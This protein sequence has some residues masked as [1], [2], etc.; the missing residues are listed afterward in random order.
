MLKPHRVVIDKVSSY[1]D[2]AAAFMRR[3]R[4][5][6]RE[7]VRIRFQ[8]GAESDLPSGAPEAD[9]I[10]AAARRLIELG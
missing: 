9:R 6:R 10:A 3:R 8:S 1:T 5:H 4:H 7:F 2:E